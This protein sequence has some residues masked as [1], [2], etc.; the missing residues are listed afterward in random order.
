MRPKWCFKNHRK[1]IRNI[2]PENTIF[3]KLWSIIGNLLQG[4]HLYFLLKRK[5]LHILVTKGLFWCAIPIFNNI[6][7]FFMAFES[8]GRTIMQLIKNPVRVH[9]SIKGNETVVYLAKE[10]TNISEHYTQ[11]L[12]YTLIFIKL[13]TNVKT[14]DLL[15]DRCNIITTGICTF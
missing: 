7:Q 6:T 8:P 14:I 12:P 4:A 15:Q 3:F 2:F 1:Y 5:C 9:S 11:L 10:A 13:Q